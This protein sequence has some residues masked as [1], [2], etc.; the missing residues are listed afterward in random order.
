L[1]ILALGNV[2]HLYPLPKYNPI[3]TPLQVEILN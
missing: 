2:V 3:S 1:H